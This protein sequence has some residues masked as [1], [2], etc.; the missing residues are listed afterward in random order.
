MNETLHL[1]PQERYDR[2]TKKVKNMGETMRNK[3]LFLGLGVG[4]GIAVILF[5]VIFSFMYRSKA[6]TTEVVADD[7]KK[8]VTIFDDINKQCGIISFDYQQNHINFLNVGTFKSSE[9]GSMNLKYADKW[10]GPYVDDNPSVQGKEY[11]VV[12]TKK[13]YFITPGKGVKLPNGKV[14]GEGII[15]NEEADIEA[16]M[17]NPNKLLF[18]NKA[19]AAPLNLSK[20]V[21]D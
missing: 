17:R 3:N 13:G 11:M 19:F 5:S 7:I 4:I 12:R 20:K 6:L 2:Y 16:M 1:F 18:K 10:Q 15:L 21:S 8:L 9:L 14:I